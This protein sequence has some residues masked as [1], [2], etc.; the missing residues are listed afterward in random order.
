MKADSQERV[1]TRY[2]LRG[3]V[4]IAYGELHLTADEVEYEESTGE[5]TADGDIQ[6]SERLQDARIRARHAVYNLRQTT[7][8]FDNVEGSIGGIISSGTALL[9]TTNPYY[10]TAETVE[11]VGEDTYRVYNGT[12]TVCSPTRPTWTFSAP[13]ATIRTGNSLRIQR[14]RL[15]V[16]GVP[17]FYFPYIYRSLR[18]LPRNS[19]F[20]MPS[21]GNNSRLGVML[22]DSFFWAINRSMDAEIGAE[23]W[24]KRGWSQ[25]A[26]FRMRP[27]ASSYLKL[28][29]YGV[30]DRGFGPQKEDQGGRTA[31][32][33][34]VA[35]FPSGWRGVLNY[36]YL[37][38]VTFREAFAQSYTEAV[39]SEVHSAG[40]LT[41][42]PDSLQ[43]NLLFSQIENFQSR[44]PGDAVRLRALPSAEL[45]S[46]ERPLWKNSPLWISW[47]SSAG[48][49]SRKEPGVAPASGLNTPF[50]NRLEF[51]PR[52]TL[53]LHWKAIQLTPALGFRT[54]Y[55]GDRKQ[56]GS[57]S[58]LSGESW[59][60][61]SPTLSVEWPLPSLSKLYSGAGRLYA[62]AFRHVIE[63]RVTFR[64]VNDAGDVSRALL[65]NPQDLVANTK[66]LEYSITNR[67]FVKGHGAG[68][69]EAFSWELKQ[70]YYFDPTFGGALVEGSRNVLPSSL[71]L[72]GHA[73]LDGR[74]R[75]S[76][77]ISLL[78][79]HPSGRYDVEFREDYDS[80]RHR[81]V[82]S[83]LTGNLR[84]GEAFL[85]VNHSFVR[86]SPVL[87]APSNQVGF[88]VGY[89]NSLRRGWNA[90]FAGSYDA[91]E[92]FL[93]FTAL[94]GSYNNDCCG[95]SF[96]YRRF[97]LGP[98][99]NENQFRVAFSLSNIGTFGTLKKQER[100]F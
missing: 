78:R 75:F 8:R 99:R 14:A 65:F 29:Y 32:A 56:A 33:E 59:Q 76:P 16:L 96:E 10:F 81:I 37:S 13:V 80:L 42:S 82:Q 30:V 40:F 69:R 36:N 17:V 44:T 61:G 20:L 55:Y 51:F 7:G 100:L 19:G 90:V 85:S 49:V 72:S 93:Q 26:D 11:R 63:P 25:R 88:N 15:R 6:F 34:S 53:P 12:I 1:G 66:E 97:A 41:K 92:G 68:A 62:G 77:V 94:Q 79:F 64:Y 35:F 22:G 27:T 9:T 87:A 47:E 46:V 95:I 54:A 38:S 43:F 18:R 21:L 50:L 67:V 48:M 23:Y 45:N 4:A 28:S 31:R 24:S 86:S 3:N 57:A 60:R 39:N 52:L 70:Q 74:R 71:L 91:K 83:G 98:T 5:L 89:G 84:L 73:F 58:A 2:R